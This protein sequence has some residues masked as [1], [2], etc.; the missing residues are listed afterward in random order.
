[1]LNNLI[2]N[3]LNHSQSKTPIL[4]ESKWNKNTKNLQISVQD[5]GIGIA[6]QEREKVFEPF[7]RIEKSIQKNMVGAELSKNSSWAKKKEKKE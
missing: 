2:Q 7:Y 3:A 5:F 6:K 1:M 4:I